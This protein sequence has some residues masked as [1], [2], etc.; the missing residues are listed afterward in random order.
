MPHRVCVHRR[1]Q[2]RTASGD[3]SLAPA[4]IGDNNTATASGDASGADGGDGDNSTATVR[5]SGA[6]S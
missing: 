5:G 2:H 3:G 6:R 1:Q 4:S